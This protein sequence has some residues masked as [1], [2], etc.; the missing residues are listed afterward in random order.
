MD[1]DVNMGDSFYNDIETDNDKKDNTDNAVENRDVGLDEGESNDVI[2][3]NLE[4]CS[5]RT[6]RSKGGERFSKS[7]GGGGCFSNL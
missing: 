3:G 5:K 7:W 2:A 4:I 6:D 1:E